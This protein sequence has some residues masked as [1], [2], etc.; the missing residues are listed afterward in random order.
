L[1]LFDV[2][3]CRRIW[4]HFT[5]PRS[6]ESVEVAER[7]ADGLATAWEREQAFEGAGLAGGAAFV[8]FRDAGG[9]E[10][11][12]L[13]VALH[14]TGAAHVVA[15]CGNADPWYVFGG[16]AH[17]AARIYP[18]QAPE[19]AAQAE[20]L[21]EVIGNPF[22]RPTID[23]QWLEWQEGLVL[24]MARDLYAERTFDQLPVL[25]DALEDAGYLDSVLLNHCRQAKDHVRG[26]WLL[27]LLLNK[28]DA[29][30]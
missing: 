6:R 23:P 19:R 10:G 18:D 5:D 4:E 11:T 12:P 27:D 30:L 29:R 13:E 8:A 24:T 15:T 14:A 26:C 9:P 28:G 22:I 3:C 21:R 20:L 16:T 7:F 25:A 2:A 17:V 1:I